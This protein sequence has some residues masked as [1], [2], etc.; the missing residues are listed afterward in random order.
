MWLSSSATRRRLPS[1]ICDGTEGLF[2]FAFVVAVA[3]QGWV[4]QQWAAV[5]ATPGATIYEITSAYLKDSD[6]H[7]F[8]RGME[9]HISCPHVEWLQPVVLR[10][11][12]NRIG[13]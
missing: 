12:A 10:N 1:P 11:N 6:L 4:R 3:V 9:Q 2:W 7:R 13:E 8:I 5:E